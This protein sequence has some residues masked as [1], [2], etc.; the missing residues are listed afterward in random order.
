MPSIKSELRIH[1]ECNGKRFA[2]N[3]YRLPDKK[4]IIKNGRSR[5]EKMPHGSLTQIF[6]ASRKWAAGQ[7]A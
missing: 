5:S 4:F 6:N 2:L 1:I 7:F 3:C